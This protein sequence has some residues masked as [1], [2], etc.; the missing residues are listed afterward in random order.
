VNNNNN[1]NNNYN[2][3]ND[4]LSQNQRHIANDCQSVSQ[5]WCQAPFGAHDQIFIAV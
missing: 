5:S 1:N 2:N 3:N 4:S